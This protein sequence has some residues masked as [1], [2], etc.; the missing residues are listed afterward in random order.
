MIMGNFTTSDTRNGL[1]YK[2][3][4]INDNERCLTDASIC[5]VPL[6]GISKN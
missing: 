1:V 4:N 6:I 5:P 2:P 3:N